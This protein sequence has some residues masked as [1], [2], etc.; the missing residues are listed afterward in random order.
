M[1]I[2]HRLRY[3][4]AVDVAGRA[5]LRWQ[6]IRGER[7]AARCLSSSRYKTFAPPLGVVPRFKELVF[8]H[9]LT[10]RYADSCRK[11]A[12][13]TSGAPIEFLKALDYFVHYPENHAALCGVRRTAVETMKV[14]EASGYSTDL[15]SYARTDFGTIETGKTIVGRLPRP[16]LLVCCTNICQTVL[17]W[18]RVLAEEFGVP[19]IVID[20]PFIYDEVAEHTIRYVRKQI[21]EAVEIAEKVAGRSMGMKRLEDVGRLSQDAAYLW[22][23]IMERGRHVPAPL[24]VFD[25]FILMGPIVEMRGEPFTVDFYTE[26]LEELDGRVRDG[27]G[28]VRAERKRLLWDNLPIWFRVRYLSEFLGRRGVACVASTYTNAWGELAPLMTPGKPLDSMARV[29]L[30]PI[31]NRS[32]AYKLDTMKRMV[33]DFHLDGV[34]LHSDRSCKPYS[35]GQVDQRDRLVNEVGVPALLL[36]ADHSDER[37]FSEGQAE[38]R[39]EALLE[40]LE[41]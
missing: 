32:T 29:Y 8:H 21:E 30:H 17:A 6:R 28:A 39:L 13:V 25:Q 4:L 33:R 35:I 9:Y 2:F 11:V 38:G 24:T 15:C 34:I 12:W 23:Q 36:D 3:H 7:E 18:Y 20:T 31:L 1:N 19:L 40:L 5:L 14:A 26:M 37:S 10:G 41:T 22:M 16:D 27:V